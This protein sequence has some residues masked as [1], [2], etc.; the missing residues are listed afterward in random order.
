MNITGL[1]S[2]APVVDMALSQAPLQD[3]EQA[4]EKAVEAGSASDMSAAEFNVAVSTQ[5]TDMA[6]NVFEDTAAQLIASMNAFTGIGQRIDM[7]V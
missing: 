3:V 6:Q 7:E 5:V 4:A 2:T 1:T